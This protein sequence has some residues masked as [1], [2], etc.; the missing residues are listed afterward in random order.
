[1]F[2]IYLASEYDA[3]LVRQKA[4]QL[5]KLLGYDIHE[6][7][8]IATAVSE[9][10]RISLNTL[11]EGE[12]TF[13]LGKINDKT[14][15]VIKIKSY[16]IS[17]L[18]ETKKLTTDTKYNINRQSSVNYP[19]SLVD[20]FQI[21]DI[22]GEGTIII[23]GKFLPNSS[24]LMT[25][26]NFE[27]VIKIINDMQPQNFLEDISQ[28]NQEILNTL[29]ELKKKQEQINE[30]NKELLETN[31]G[32]IALSN[33]LEEKAESLRKSNEVKKNFLLNVSHEF[34]TPIHSILGMSGLLLERIDGELNKEQEKQV[35][36]IQKAAGELL[37]MVSDILDLSKIEAGKITIHPIEFELEDVF[38]ALRGM[39]KPLHTKKN[40]NLIFQ[41]PKNLPKLYTDDKKLSQIIRNFISNALKF[42]LEG[43]I[44]VSS[45]LSEN[46]KYLTVFV[47]DTGI[48]IPKEEQDL[49]FKEFSQIDSSIQKIVKGTGLGL[50]LSKDFALLLG[51]NISVESELNV[52]SVFSVTFPIIHS[53]IRDIYTENVD[54]NSACNNT[55][56]LYSNKVLV[57]DDDKSFHYLLQKTISNNN[58]IILEASDGS[59]GLQYAIN[60]KPDVILLD[61]VMPVLSGYEVLTRL[62]LNSITKDIP[63]FILTSDIL[64]QFEHDK[65]KDSVVEIFYK[66]DLLDKVMINNLKNKI[67]SFVI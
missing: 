18:K 9:S 41:L 37:E 64:S 30:L 13:S 19:S 10:V 20:K 59:E 55:K 33:E 1:M 39:F 21:E 15:L 66:K 57:I 3:I 16:E 32:V 22:P 12:I 61:L 51:G 29:V 26:E 56:H 36:F 67:S 24:L 45:K 43:E 27:D 58:Y 38:S 50:S 40:V 49:I 6:Q 46:G 7:V 60:E 62:K 4:Q 35:L 8:R 25:E 14:M 2:K 23:L 48:G 54:F 63:V 17:N 28:Q 53:D 42:T 34:K 5:S 47:K 52:G 31:K 65:I 11:S 44:L